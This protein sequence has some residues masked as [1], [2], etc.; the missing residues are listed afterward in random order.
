LSLNRDTRNEVTNSFRRS[1]RRYLK[2]S[3]S[4]SASAKVKRPGAAQAL[5]RRKGE[6]SSVSA[7]SSNGRIT[8]FLRK[9]ILRAI[10]SE[11]RQGAQQSPAACRNGQV[12]ETV[13]P[14]ALDPAISPG[15]ELGIT[16]AL[17]I[18]RWKRILDVACVVLSLPLWLP[19]MLL[20]MAWTRI[21]SPGPIFYRQER[22]GFHGKR[23]MIFKL[24]TMKVNA[25][26]RTHEEYF[27][28]LMRSDSP[29]RKL[30]SSGDSRLIPWGRFLRACGLDELPQVFNVLRGDMSLVGP[31]PCTPHEFE[32]YQPWEKQRVNA[33]PGLTG[34]WQV[35][36]KNKTTFQQMIAMD[37][38]YMRNMS[39]WL[40]LNIILK[41]VPVLAW[42]TLAAWSRYNSRKVSREIA[43]QSDQAVT[44]T[45]TQRI[46]GEVKRA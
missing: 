22:I 45:A 14:G 23:F 5:P 35:N 39:L 13:L 15:P 32:R 1:F 28:S 16:E 21:S 6:S 7:S 3:E 41:T 4:R 38:F 19:L 44:E 24:R 30:D 2:K 42:E 34:Y 27:A 43:L 11:Q 8:V 26:T 29:M 10:A 12:K 17:R 25:D 36:G 37:I 18:P 9:I 46:G 31:R 40:D 33:A 20:V